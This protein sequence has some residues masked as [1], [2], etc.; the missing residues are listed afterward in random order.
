MKHELILENLNC[1]HCASKIESKIAETE[2]FERVS[3][4]FATKK[5]SFE[6]DSENLIAQV[7]SICDSI[8]DGVKVKLYSEHGSHEHHDRHDRCHGGGC[9][10]EHE[11]SHSHGHGKKG[12]IKN[13][14]LAA[15]IALGAAALVLHLLSAG[16]AAHW[17]VFALSL[18]A[19]L[20]AGYDVFLKGFKNAFR[21]RIEETVLITVA[22]IAAFF[23]GE[24]VEAAMVTILFS[25]GEFI[26]D[27]AVGKSRRDIEKLSQIRP[28][29]A[30][31]LEG[32]KEI[33][34]PADSVKIG[35]SIL[36]KPHE[37]IPLDGVVISGSSSLD[38]SALTGESLPQSAG[39]GS[40]VLS[41]AMNG[42]GLLTLRTTKEF[43]DSTATRILRLVEDA[44]AKKGQREKL[45]TRFANIYTPIVVGLAFLIAVLPPLLGLGSFS[46]WIYRA[47]VV[48]V[49][50]CPCAIV[51]SVPLSYYSGIGAGSR[52][53]VLIKGSK[54]LEV[55]AKAD[56]F[57]FDKTGT[58]TTGK[59]TV[60][61]VY[62]CGGFSKKEVL[63]LAAACEKYST[64]P[65]AVAI[66]EKSAESEIALS[67]YREIA[68]CGTSAIYNGK[69]LLCGN[70]KL[71]SQ[72]VPEELRGKNAVYLIYGGKLIGALEIS[73]ALRPEAKDVLSQLDSLGIKK[74]LMLTGDAEL[75][76]AQT[77]KQ[78]GSIEY[79]AELM[80]QD[81]LSEITKIQESGSAV[82]FV[83]DGINDAPV[84]SKSD[85]GIAMGLGSEAAIEAA[86]AVLSSGDLS[87]LPKAI[88]LARKTI[89][90]I[91]TNIIFA[92]AVK[93]A[94]IALASL[95]MAQMWM[96]VLADTGVCVACVLYT[97]RL[98][99]I[100]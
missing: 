70:S 48:L 80:P 82:C 51:I 45:I 50:S 34:V 1:A 65:I 33:T 60:S 11:H 20:A 92:L 18:A 46:E 16:A 37:R 29:N 32:G 95:G 72:G 6:H 67:G 57:V 96:S 25:I 15:S 9:D 19:T 7:Q 97:A 74:K 55:L 44:A 79:R 52:M 30:T 23:L 93:A 5:L 4:N 62:A 83:G 41:G 13:I 3:F 91:R 53:G 100:R 88:R 98:L 63:S 61:D 78:L 56:A 59:I 35:S 24:Y 8:E 77:Q 85:C 38:L 81:K 49:A 86:D 27:L 69:E 14:L 39:A 58:L 54:Y 66:K 22:V 71:L 36:I 43:G 73:D 75:N 10:H 2:G 89:N 87:A 99:K 90:T 64:H 84:L 40:E 21:L 47:L 31:L 94:V 28:D 26:E 76:A 42:E 68:G 12:K 17:T